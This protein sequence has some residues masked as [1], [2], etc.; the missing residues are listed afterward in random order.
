MGISQTMLYRLSHVGGTS[1]YPQTR[2]A[3]TALASSGTAAW[4]R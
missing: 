2:P 1:F 4:C 3:S